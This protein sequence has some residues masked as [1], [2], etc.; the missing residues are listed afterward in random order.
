MTF[1]NVHL[2]QTSFS[3]C[4]LLSSQFILEYVAYFMEKVFLYENSPS[5]I[6]NGTFSFPQMSVENLAFEALNSVVSRQSMGKP[7][8]NKSLITPAVTELFFQGTN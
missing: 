1:L 2:R 8:I 7:M 6:F 5:V 3:K 4:Y